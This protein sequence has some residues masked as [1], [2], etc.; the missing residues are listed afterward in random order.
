MKSEGASCPGCTRLNE[1][2]VSLERRLTDVITSN[3]AKSQMLAE[4]DQE[5]MLKDKEISEMRNR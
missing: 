4:K 5:L 3:D 2:C 1:Q